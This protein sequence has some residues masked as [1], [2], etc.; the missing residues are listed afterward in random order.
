MRILNYPNSIS[1]GR[2]GIENLGFF[3]LN[4]N[5]IISVSMTENL[6]IFRFKIV[7]WYCTVPLI[8]TVLKFLSVRISGIQLYFQITSNYHDAQFSVFLI[9]TRTKFM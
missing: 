3:I 1:L 6:F 5:E 4:S 7:H 9:L 8:L 2:A